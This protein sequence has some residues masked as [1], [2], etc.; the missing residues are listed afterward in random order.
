MRRNQQ[1][2][3]NEF[4][5]NESD[6]GDDLSLGDELIIAGEQKKTKQNLLDVRKNGKSNAIHS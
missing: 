5:L 2:Q 1:R 6:D 4:D 3:T